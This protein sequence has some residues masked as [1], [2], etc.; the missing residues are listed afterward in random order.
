M[1]A[2]A[3]PEMEKRLPF[4]FC[5]GGHME[6][7]VKESKASAIAR[8]STEAIGQ[9]R[10]CCKELDPKCG[11]DVCSMKDECV[12]RWDYCSSVAAYAAFICWHT[13][14]ARPVRRRS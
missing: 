10:D 4:L 11:G 8:L 12:K 13:E 1:R 5:L 2:D 6:T 3:K 9:M 7:R 14:Q